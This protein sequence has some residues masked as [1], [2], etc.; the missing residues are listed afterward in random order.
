MSWRDEMKALPDLAP[1]EFEI[2]PESVALVTI[3]MQYFDAHPDYGLGAALRQSHPDVWS[4][5]TGR[6][7]EVA[8]PNC[9]R[10]LEAFRAAGRLVVHVTHGPDLP[11]GSD[12]VRVLRRRPDGDNTVYPVGCFEH[13]S[14]PQLEPREGELVINKKSRSAFSTTA[15][16][17]VL[18]N[19]GIDTLV[20][21]GVTTSS[22]VETTAR[23]ASDRGFQVVVV[24]DAVAELDEVAHEATLRQI[25][26]R[27]G[28]VWTTD[29]T[30]ETVSH[31]PSPAAVR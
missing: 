15:I 30:L 9:A 25:A 19:A 17:I 5:Y 24:E 28:R 22:C 29:E 16:D 12:L 18:R 23:D 31:W 4:Y 26:M 10:L 21:G 7:E 27:F 8:I 1:A 3:D 14:L 20:I 13:R 11:D 6:L 2:V